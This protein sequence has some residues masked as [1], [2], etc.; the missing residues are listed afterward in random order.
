MMSALQ[1]STECREVGLQSGAIVFQDLQVERTT[2]ELQ[3]EIAKSVEDVAAVISTPSEI[4]S[5]PEVASF[6]KIL[7]SVG[8][9]PRKKSPTVELLT[10]MAIKRGTLPAVNSLVDAYNLVSLRTRCSLGAH[11]TDQIGLPVE[12]RVFSHASRF[13]PL[14][15]DSDEVIPRANSGTST[16][17]SAFFVGSISNKQ[18]SA[19]LPTPRAMCC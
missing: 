14:G 4:R 16:R 18:I 11:D 3:A 1:V 10:R 19:R 7:K 9:D 6:R 17:S 15:A 8:V 5:L 2:P 13:V 12:L